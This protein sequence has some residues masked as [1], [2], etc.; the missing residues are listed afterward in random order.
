MTTFAP[1]QQQV[2]HWISTHTPG[3]FTPLMMLARMSEELGE[4]AR[5]VSH[6]HGDKRPKPGE[7]EGD[8]AEEIADLIFVLVCLANEQKLDLDKAWEGLLEK[9]YVR[10]R[11][12]W[13]PAPP[14]GAES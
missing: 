4:L 9:L 7:K 3:Y 1:I 8:I 5:A 6:K 13:K 11:D 10:D 14:A 12:R 2:D